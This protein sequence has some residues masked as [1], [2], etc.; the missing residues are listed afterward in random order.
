M[1]KSLTPRAAALA[2]ALA[3]VPFA[4]CGYVGFGDEP[5][6]SPVT[7]QR[8]TV[9]ITAT[10]VSPAT[11]R[12]PT[13]R[14]SSCVIYVLFL[15]GDGEVHDIRSDPHPEHT[16]CR[17]LNEVGRLEPGGSREVS[18]LDCTRPERWVG[19]HDETRL[20]DARFQGRVEEQ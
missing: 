17:A 16:Q 15:N 6:L 18:M 2:A 20:G 8:L 1:W 19:Y 13:C 14:S 7:P 10:V 3:N 4:S 11:V 12:P 9:T 5:F